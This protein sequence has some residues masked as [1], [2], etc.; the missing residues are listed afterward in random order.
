MPLVEVPVPLVPRAAIP[1]QVRSF[2]REANHR[3]EE[4]QMRGGVPGFVPSDYAGAYRVL[5]ALA[6]TGLP[7]ANLFCEWG[8]GFGVV[9]CLAAMLDFEACGIEIERELVESARRLAEDYDL[10][11]EFLHGS[12]IPPGG[13]AVA[14]SVE[15][16]SWLT[17][18]PGRTEELGLGPEDFDVIFV[19]PWPDEETVTEKLF[20]GYA[21][22]GALLLSY[23]GAQDFRLRRKVADGSRSR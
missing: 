18:E 8:S 20:E 15:G 9:T 3:I 17:T 2:L 23:H 11:V 19:Y 6:A 16:F 22:A 1:S 14:A 12:F 10:A 5:K 21:D 7:R 4:F 13:E